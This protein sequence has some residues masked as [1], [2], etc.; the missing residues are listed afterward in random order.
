MA[1]KNEITVEWQEDYSTGIAKLDEQHKTIISYLNEFNAL[2]MSDDKRAISAILIKLLGYTLTHFLDEE[3]SMYAARYTEFEKHRNE[4]NRF[5]F[6]LR[7]LYIKFE[8]GNN[9]R[10]VCAEI[11]STLKEWFITHISDT[12]KKYGPFLAS[13][14][15]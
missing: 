12:D 8:G 6:E 9:S 10:L 13:L 3:I 11:A 2:A 4:H 15:P 7:S 5:F 1:P 14:E